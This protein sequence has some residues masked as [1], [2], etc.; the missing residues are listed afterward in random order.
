MDKIIKFMKKYWQGAILGAISSS[1]L[2]LCIERVQVLDRLSVLFIPGT[3]IGGFVFK[4]LESLGI[5]ATSGGFES[6]AIGI[7]II[8]IIN[9]LIFAIVGAYV[10]KYIRGGKK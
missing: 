4:L 2:L 5:I 1:V 9:I 8:T 7:I 6:L 3:M 10:E